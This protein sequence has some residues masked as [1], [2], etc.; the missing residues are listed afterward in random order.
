MQTV[1]ISKLIRKLINVQETSLKVCRKPKIHLI[2]VI[3]Q[4]LSNFVFIVK[5]QLLERY[6]VSTGF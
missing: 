1:I 6:S 4:R 3:K 5:A 2:A